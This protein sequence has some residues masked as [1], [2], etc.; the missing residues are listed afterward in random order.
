MTTL[1]AIQGDI[2]KLAVDAVVNAA[3]TS[4][5]G[6]GGL[7]GAIHRAAGPD[8]LEE[9]MALGGCPVGEARLTR[10]YLLPARYIIHAAGPVWRGGS[11][12]E[13]ALLESCYLNSLKIA[14]AREF[15]TL[16]FPAIA[17]GVF[18]Y[19]LWPA[20]K[21]AIR[22]VRQFIASPSSLKEVTLCCFTAG[23]LK[24]YEQLLAEPP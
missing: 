19:P 24:I 20:T 1:R 5:L 16:A 18:G 2:T 22:T 14:A 4:L 8:L 3:N 6:G 15:S 23:D 21:V 9:C 11:Q 10:G 7:D 17:T 13:E 12:G